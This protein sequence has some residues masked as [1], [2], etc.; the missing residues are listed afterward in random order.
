MARVRSIFD[1]K[2]RGRPHPSEV[3]VA[4]QVVSLSDGTALLQLSSFGSDARASE[5]KVSQ[6]LQFD[7]DTALA[8]AQHI[9]GC[10]GTAPQEP[11][12]PMKG[13]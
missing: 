2:Q 5:A 13:R 6:T 8:L 4:V 11:S 9:H 3:D 7:R 1:G 10:F 12:G